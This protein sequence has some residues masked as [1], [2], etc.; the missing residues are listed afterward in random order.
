MNKS[1]TNLPLLSSD[2]KPI[3]SI[4]TALGVLWAKKI[5]S[6]FILSFTPWLPKVEQSATNARNPC[7][8]RSCHSTALLIL[9]VLLMAF[10]ITHTEGHPSLMRDLP[11]VSL[12]FC[13]D[14]N[15]LAPVVIHSAFCFVCFSPPVL[16]KGQCVTKYYRWM[17]KNGGYIW[18]QSSATIAINA[19]NA[20]EKNIIWVNYLLRYIF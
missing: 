18:I 6:H 13:G 20:N 5:C 1:H 16:N 15:H 8:L 4:H 7:W 14:D 12:R 2:V 10:C 9:S 19:K 3:D 11:F 17:Q